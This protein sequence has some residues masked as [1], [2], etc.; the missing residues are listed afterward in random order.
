MNVAQQNANITCDILILKY[1][2]SVIFRIKLQSKA[3]SR[4]GILDLIEFSVF[5]FGSS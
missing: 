5:G 4:N 3:Y 1:W 2:H